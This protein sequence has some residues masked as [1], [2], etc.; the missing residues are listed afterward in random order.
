MFDSQ[1]GERLQRVVIP[2]NFR[3]ILLCALSLMAGIILCRH[4]LILGV[5]TVLAPA[6]VI[7][8][9]CVLFLCL[10]GKDKRLTVVMTSAFCF[11]FLSIG[12]VSFWAKINATVKDVPKDGYYTVRGEVSDV[13]YKQGLWYA[14]LTDCTYDGVLGSDFFTYGLDCEVKLYDIIE[15]KSIVASDKL[16]EGTKLSYR[17]L[18]GW[19]TYA[20][21]VYSCKVVGK[22][23]SIA[24][25]FKILTDQKFKSVLGEDSGILSALLRG[26]DSEMKETVTLF[27]LVGIAHIFAVSGMHVGL[28]FTALSFLLGKIKINRI[29]KTLIIAGALVFYSYLCGFTP[30]SLRAVIMCICLMLS[31]FFGEK[32]D[33]LNALAEAFIIVLL[34]N[35]VDL[36]SAGFILSFS[37]CLSILILSPPIK[38]VLSFMPEEFASLFSVLFASQLT[39]LPLSIWFFGSFPLA[40]FIANFFLLPIVSI[41]YYATVICTIIAMILPINE[42]IA[43]FVPQIL[44]VGIKNV[45]ELIAKFPLNLTYMTKALMIG[46]Y[47]L[48]FGVSDIIN[49]PKKAKFSCGV[50]VLTLLFYLSMRSFFGVPV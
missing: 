30:S 19:P 46:Y 24:S 47:T 28:V 4:Y 32:H 10:V 14:T 11:L 17:I 44:T 29:I 43:L 1:G 22:S 8:A 34:I 37:I 9:I 23:T 36:F 50:L 45:T 31:K 38:R 33:G 21:K 49:L 13:Y 5:W 48:L 42:L 39:A 2:I 41:L 15:I 3:P 35:A 6:I 25:R 40:S 16:G 12:M 27:R 7:L 20:R 18:N 26:D